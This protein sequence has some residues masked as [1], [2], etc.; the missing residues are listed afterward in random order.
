MVLSG[1][2]VDV[3]KSL[4]GFVCCSCSLLDTASG[5]V[6]FPE[7]VQEVQEVVGLV[8]QSQPGAHKV[9]PSSRA[10]QVLCHC[11]QLGGKAATRIVLS[12][13]ILHVA[14]LSK[15]TLG[16]HI[17]GQPEG[18]AAHITSKAQ[19]DH[20]KRA[21]WAHLPGTR[22]HLYCRRSIQISGQT[23]LVNQQ[24]QEGTV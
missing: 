21:G 18:N 6:P 4:P 11:F 22:W 14:T 17:T 15:T 10:E 13:Q 12:P 3:Q 7:M 24:G 2:S 19:P 9:C 16:F 23:Q 1:K 20:N 8:F 5:K